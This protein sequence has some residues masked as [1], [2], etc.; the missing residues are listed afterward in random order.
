MIVV[1]LLVMFASYPRA[2]GRVH[3]RLQG[4]LCGDLEDESDPIAA[5]ED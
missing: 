5:R 1:L 3:Q 4:L 2:G